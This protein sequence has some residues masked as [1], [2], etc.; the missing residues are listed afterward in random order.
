MTYFN[1]WFG[2]NAEH[3]YTKYDANKRTVNWDRGFD[4]YSDYFLG[5]NGI[6]TLTN[7]NENA[8]ILL[9]TMSKVIGID[10]KKFIQ[11]KLISKDFSKIVIPTDMLKDESIS[12]DVFLGA[13]L[14]NIAQNQYLS[15]SE[16]KTLD[17]NKKNIDL[18]KTVYGILNAERVNNLMAEDTPGYLKFIQ[19]YKK[20]KYLSRP[21]TSSDNKYEKALDL[22]D[23]IIRFPEFITEKDYT[24]FKEP[25]DNIKNL[26][27]KTKGIP[28]TNA[29]CINLSKKISTILEQFIEKELEKEDK[30]DDINPDCDSKSSDSSEDIKDKNDEDQ[31]ETESSSKEKDESSKKAAE[32]FMKSLLEYEDVPENKDKNIFKDFIEKIKEEEENSIHKIDKSVIFQIAED[33]P[34]SYDIVANTI[35]HSKSAVIGKLLQRKNRDYQFNLKSMRS[36]RLDTDK[37]A[38]AKQGVQTIYERIGSVKTNKLCV[39]I[40]VDE[41]GSMAG[42]KETSARKAAIF[43]KESLESVPDVELF[44]YGHTADYPKSNT[45]SIYI[46]KEPGTVTP[47]KC[48]GS[49]SA[50]RENRDGVAI[51]SVAKRV[52]QKTHNNGV[53]IVISDGQPSA[54]NYSGTTARNHV[55][56]AAIETE[57]MGFH[58]IQVT[59]GGYRSK[60]MFKNV[61]EMNDINTFPQQFVSFIKSKVNNLI[62][63]KIT[64]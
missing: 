9:S 62:K 14:Q 36:G 54:E 42:R 10:S 64:I 29:G 32:K 13:A 16:L 34:Y 55:K 30:K 52:R 63:E 22:F 25:F 8:A 53:F 50:K 17:K 41:S 59:I 23:K 46:Y 26:I 40:L 11:N 1:D 43:L 15:S 58:V 35:D 31:K 28:S 45:T 6:S 49:I 20:H 38:E 57:K 5:K 4:N 39:T 47:S 19:K 21:A 18:Q 24:E 3:A 51:I 33:R 56:K 61:I 12:T 37:L 2:R 7:K 60:D 27:S 44:I 48:M